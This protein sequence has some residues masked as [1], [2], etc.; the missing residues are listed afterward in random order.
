MPIRTGPVFLLLDAKTTRLASLALFFGASVWG[1]YWVP[2]RMLD[3]MGVAGGWAVAYFN[4]C[5]LLVLV[6]YLIW[7]RHSVFHLLGPALFIG[8]ATGLGLALYSTSIVLGSVVRI[9]MEFYLTSVWSSIIGVVWLQER[10]D[11]R[12]ALTVAAG[13]AGLGLLLSG[14]ADE[15]A[16]RLGLAD[17]MGVSSGILWAFGAAGMKRWP[18]AHLAATTSFQFGFAVIGGVALQ[19]AVLGGGV[20]TVA[21]FGNALPPALFLSILILL[22]SICLMFWACRLLFPGRAAILMMSEAVVAVISATLFLPD[23]TMTG[24]QWLGAGI[25]L[26]A[27]L[28]GR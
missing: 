20:P 24:Q 4:F 9:T 15:A 16:G 27:C 6:P 3:G 12:R 2:L 18:D 21:Q 22:P 17:V 11:L 23:E 19:F 1:V 14:G 10:A 13:L 25:V 5:P 7:Q 26:L 28:L 8:A